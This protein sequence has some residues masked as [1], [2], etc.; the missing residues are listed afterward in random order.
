MEILA[1][2][3]DLSCAGI[4]ALKEDLIRRI[5]IFLDPKP[6]EKNLKKD[7]TFSSR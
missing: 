6:F 1:S 3:W 5:E 7:S 2:Q 4:R